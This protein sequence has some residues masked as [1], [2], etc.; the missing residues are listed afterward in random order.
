MIFPDFLLDEVNEYGQ[1]VRQFTRNARWLITSQAIRHFG[2]GV[3]NAIFNLYLLTLG[4]NNTFI[5]DRL[6]AGSL[7]FAFAALSVVA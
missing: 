5:G 2:N 1:R 7:V 4:Y 3:A 6:F